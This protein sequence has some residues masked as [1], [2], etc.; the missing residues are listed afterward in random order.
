MDAH[1]S[2]NI[3]QKMMKKIPKIYSKLLDNIKILVVSQM[4]N[5]MTILRIL[6]LMEKMKKII[7]LK[8][9]S[10]MTMKMKRIIGKMP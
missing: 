8:R 1:I 3:T 2:G 4:N 6:K 7:I 9:R 10:S 5:I